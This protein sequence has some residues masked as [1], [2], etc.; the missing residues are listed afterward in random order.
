MRLGAWEGGAAV[1][2]WKLWVL[3]PLLA[4][5]RVVLVRLWGAAAVCAWVLCATAGCC[6]CIVAVA[7]RPSP[8]CR[9]SVLLAAPRYCKL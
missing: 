6:W 8:P 2:A 7:A 5:G 9:N 4:L 1:C 3:V